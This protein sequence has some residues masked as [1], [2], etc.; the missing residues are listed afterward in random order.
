MKKLLLIL[1]LSVIIQ[2]L[3]AQK[4]ANVIPIP[5]S[6]TMGQGQF[7]MHAG[8]RILSS[9]DFADEVYFLQKELLR[10]Q[11][12]SSTIVENNRDAEIV[13]EKKKLNNDQLYTL[14]VTLEQIKIQAETKE[15]AFYGIIYCC[16]WPIIVKVNQLLV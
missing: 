4:T 9:T 3:W 2:P 8:L 6:S 12:L 10:Y 16:S 1:L 7:K 14:D 15:G 5:T 13:L 11:K